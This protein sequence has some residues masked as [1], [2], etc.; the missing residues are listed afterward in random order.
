[1]TSPFS[2]QMSQTFLRLSESL[3]PSESFTPTVPSQ[4]STPQSSQ[5]SQSS[6]STQGSDTKMSIDIR[7]Y[8]NMENLKKPGII[9]SLCLIFLF[10]IISA[11]RNKIWKT[12]EKQPGYSKILL[13][14]VI[15]SIPLFIWI[16]FKK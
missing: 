16:F 9:L 11:M 12:K 6:Q 3:K 2:Q 15:T 10:M 13:Y 5:S 14:I 7:K 4:P 1:M 8:L